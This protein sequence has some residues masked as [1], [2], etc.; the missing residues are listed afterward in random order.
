MARS[1]TNAAAVVVA[2]VCYAVVLTLDGWRVGAHRAAINGFTVYMARGA[3]GHTL[4]IR[5]S[6]GWYVGKGAERGW[7]GSFTGGDGGEAGVAGAAVAAAGS[8][9]GSARAGSGRA[10]STGSGAWWRTGSA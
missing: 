4:H 10:A 3:Y 6:R 1:L 9:A 5:R 2:H 8:A 7:A